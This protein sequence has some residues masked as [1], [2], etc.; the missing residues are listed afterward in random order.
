MIYCSETHRTDHHLLDYSITRKECNIVSDFTVTVSRFIAMH[1]R[2][3]CPKQKAVR[4][5]RAIEDDSLEGCH[6]KFS[7]DQRC[8]D[9]DIMTEK[10]D[11][12]ISD[13]LDKHARI[14]NIYYVL[15]RPLNEW[16]TANIL[17]SSLKN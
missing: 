4:N 10:Y 8:A 3:P 1:T 12:F 15:D 7:I 16:I 17:N 14:R 5:R 9:V 6:E 11:R 13:L 2:S